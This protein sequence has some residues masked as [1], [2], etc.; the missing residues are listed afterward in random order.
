MENIQQNINSN[1]IINNEDIDIELKALPFTFYHDETP[2]LKYNNNGNKVICPKYIL[3]ELSKYENIVYPITLKYKDIYLGV[4][5]FKEFID[6]IY[7]PNHIFYNSNLIENEKI[8]LKI[9][10][11]PLPKAT[12]IKIKPQCE[13]FYKIEDKKKYLE[14]HLRNLYTIISEN[15]D[16]TLIYGNNT[17]SLT[18]LECKPEPNVSIDEIEELEIDIEPIIKSKPKPKIISSINSSLNKKTLKKKDNEND[19][20]FKPFSGKGRTLGTK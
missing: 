5:E 4:L 6:E 8:E 20:E 19:D 16:L 11:K 13:D 15:T 2:K 18:I 9:L 7:I 10:H 17:I 12:Y 1:L 14:A 3:Y